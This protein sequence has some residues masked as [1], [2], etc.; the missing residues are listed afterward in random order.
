M[1]R[2]VRL[3]M[4]GGAALLVA[5]ASPA[6]MPVVPVQQAPAG[7]VGDAPA[8]VPEIVESVQTCARVTL[9]GARIDFRHLREN[10]WK[11]GNRSFQLL[12]DSKLGPDAGEL[13]Y[14]FGRGNS[15]LA[16]RVS[17]TQ[18]RCR[19][20]ARVTGKEQIAAVR[21]ALIGGKIALPF[22]Q[23]PGY[24]AFKASMRERLPDSDFSNVLLSGQHVFMLSL[25]EKPDFLAVWVDV[26]ALSSSAG[27]AS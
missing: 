2:T 22:D 17:P 3:G 27:G 24:V 20:V 11:I 15:V 23:A 8:A 4:L 19:I 14:V 21:T 9:P 6:P 10:G 16:T 12:K 7:A 13:I 26:W 5:A 1:T 25:Q 18:A